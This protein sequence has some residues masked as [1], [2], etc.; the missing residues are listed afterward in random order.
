MGIGYDRVSRVQ[1]RWKELLDS[2]KSSV[3]GDSE[4]SDSEDTEGSSDSSVC[5]TDLQT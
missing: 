2:P 3:A 5:C 4:T 1:S